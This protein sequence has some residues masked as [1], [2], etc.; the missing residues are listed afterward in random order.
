MTWYFFLFPVGWTLLALSV[1]LVNA[2]SGLTALYILLTCV[3]FAIFLLIPG[4]IAFRWLAKATGSSTLLLLTCLLCVFSLPPS[5]A[6][7][8]GLV[9]DN[10]NDGDVWI[11]LLH[12]YYRCTSYFWYEFI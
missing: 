3:G 7:S 2:G 8:I 10:N 12:R 1:A 11:F 9:Y 4:K 5:R 6:W